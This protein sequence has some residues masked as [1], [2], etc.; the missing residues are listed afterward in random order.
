MQTPTAEE[1]RNTESELPKKSTANEVALKQEQVKKT[2]VVVKRYHQE[3]EE[4]DEEGRKEIDSV[5]GAFDFSEK[6]SKLD[7]EVENATNRS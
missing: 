5:V 7:L 4:G 1:S 2:N 3:E 6:M